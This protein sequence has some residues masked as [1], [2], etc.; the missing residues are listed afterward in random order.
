MAKAKLTIKG[1]LLAVTPVTPEVERIVVDCATYNR[2]VSNGRSNRMKT[3]PCYLCSTETYDDGTPYLLTF[4]GLYNRVA[5]ALKKAG[6]EIESET[7]AQQ[8]LTVDVSRLTDEDLLNLD[9]R[10]DQTHVLGL[11]VDNP[12]GFV[13]D[14]PTGW[15]K[16]YIIAQICQMLP[17][18]KIA[19]V[20]PGKEVTKMLYRRLKERIRDVGQVGDGQNYISR[21][22]VCTSESLMKLRHDDWDLLLYDEVHRAGAPVTAGAISEVFKTAKC[23]GFSASP[24]GR[25]DGADLVVEALFGP[26]IYKVEYATSVGRGD[27]A[28]IKVKAYRIEK[29]AP[30]MTDLSVVRNRHGLWRNEI[31]NSFIAAIAN[32][33][34][35]DEQALIMCA[36][37]EHV[38]YLYKWLPDFEVIFSKMSKK[39]LNAVY[40]GDFGHING[41]DS[42]GNIT[43]SR[44]GYMR[45]EFES[46]NMKRVIATGIWNTGVDFTHLKWLIRADGMTSD[47]LSIQT[48]GRL[49]RTSD[50]KGH[51][52]LVDFID[53]FDDSLARRSL[54]RMRRY[55]KNGWPIEEIRD[56]DVCIK[57][58]SDARVDRRK[59][60]AA[61]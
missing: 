36:T 6:I 10:D 15:G 50:G 52:T 45:K 49:S 41:M 56:P 27:I 42:R 60:G 20:S 25:S 37:A 44:R 23:V 18:H 59:T 48:P 54:A 32:E 12:G 17:K 1:S 33:I 5:A 34:P 2:R 55:R 61:K 14:A 47:I 51:G 29:G 11:I 21:V 16:S 38:L 3:E 7:L 53:A 46:G 13:V 28:P 58:L 40:K 31:R 9:G 26:V 19:V 24:T 4:A 22:T 39:T 57:T 35:E 43:A 8:V 30:I